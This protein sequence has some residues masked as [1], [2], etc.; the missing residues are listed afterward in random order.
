MLVHMTEENTDG[1]LPPA[2]TAAEDLASMTPAD[3]ISSSGLSKRL[4]VAGIVGTAV[5]VGFIGV[6]TVQGSS[7][8][9]TASNG[10]GGGPAGQF[11]QGGPAG[12][13]PVGF[14]DR[15]VQGTVE[16]ISS[17]SITVAGTTVKI[18]SATQVVIDGAQGSLS[19]VKK[20][21][22]VFVHTEGSG[23]SRWAE[24]IFVGSFG[25]GGFG[26]PGFG[27]PPGRQQGNGTT[28]HT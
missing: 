6:L 8:S 17:S 4:K 9:P 14:A 20:G 10:P 23:T 12:G 19:D 13:P 5:V 2:P 25:Q 16:A 1:V 7:A 28:A 11:R 26:G 15:G 21:A 3:E 18:T 22:T 27:P 24:R